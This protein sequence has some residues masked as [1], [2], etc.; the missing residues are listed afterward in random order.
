MFGELNTSC[1]RC[2]KRIYIPDPNRLRA[3]FERGVSE[4]LCIRCRVDAAVS[5]GRA[6]QAK[7][8]NPEARKARHAEEERQHRERILSTRKAEAERWNK[9]N[10]RS[11]SQAQPNRQRPANDWGA[12]RS[13]YVSKQAAKIRETHNQ[14][15]VPE[16]GHASDTDH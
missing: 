16:Q 2:G 12:T 15:W 9:S 6:E 3:R 14:R 8:D 10:R 4:F 13:T 11:V 1:D 5:K 7:R